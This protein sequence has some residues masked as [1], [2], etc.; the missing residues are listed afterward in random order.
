[1][2][3][4]GFS[5]LELT[6][7]RFLKITCSENIFLVANYKER[8][9]LVRLKCI[10]KDNIFLEP[11]SKNTAAAVLLFLFGFK[12]HHA[13][14]S[15]LIISPVDHL[16]KEEK[17][18]YEA[19]DTSLNVARDGWIC[20]LGIKPAQPTPNYG[21]IQ[22][23]D[24]LGGGIFSITRFIEKPTRMMAAELIKKGDSFYNSGMFVASTATLDKEYKKYYPYYREF[25]DA[26]AKSTNS[27]D[28][29]IRNLYH[30]IE[31]IPFDKA[32]MER[33]KKGRLIKGNFYWKDFGSWHAIYDVLPKDKNGNV[34]RGNAF[35][36]NGENN[37]AYLDDTKKEIL[38]MGLE[39]IVFV[40]T[41]KYT[42]LTH[43]S[44]L[45]DLKSAL[46]RMKE[47]S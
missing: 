7:K 33:T 41:E 44:Q 9:D 29:N 1:M 38:I 15:A 40:D 2:D 11:E 43:R 32:I 10:K 36:Y 6:I 5:P 20:T 3:I 42:L 45:D 30:I 34:K 23:G 16:I 24:A 28:K 31:D 21:Y 19:L 22:A 12:K 26:F 14:D 8:D 4:F 35:V 37:L 18:F 17:Y 46:K 27:L 47:S 13:G 39:G 25:A